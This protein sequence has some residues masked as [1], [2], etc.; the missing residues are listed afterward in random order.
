MTAALAHPIVL[1]D[2]LSPLTGGERAAAVLGALGVVLVTVATVAAAVAALRATW[3]G[4]E[5]GEAGR[6]DDPV[7]ANFGPNWSDYQGDTMERIRCRARVAEACYEGRRSDGIYGRDGT[8]SH[9]GTFNGDSVVCD[10]CYIA[11]GQP[12]LTEI[13]DAIDRFREARR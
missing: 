10:P 1:A 8:M 5:A 3:T 6:D 7:A 4:P 2:V 13:P 12:L 11:L 9:D